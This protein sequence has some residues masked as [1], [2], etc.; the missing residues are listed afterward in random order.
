MFWK[1]ACCCGGTNQ[2]SCGCGGGCSTGVLEWADF[3]QSF[4]ITYTL[5]SL[6]AHDTGGYNQYISDVSFGTYCDPTDT[7]TYNF[8]GHCGACATW[9]TGRIQNKY[10]AGSEI[11]EV[12]VT[13]TVLMA[14]Q[15]GTNPN[16]PAQESCRA[17]YSGTVQEPQPGPQA[18]SL[19]CDCA[20]E[21]NFPGFSR[22]LSAIMQLEK[23]TPNTKITLDVYDG[24]WTSGDPLPS[25][26]SGSPPPGENHLVYE[27]IGGEL[28]KDINGNTNC[29]YCYF[30]WAAFSDLSLVAGGQSYPGAPPSADGSL[31]V[32]LSHGNRDASLLCCAEDEP[33]EYIPLAID[34]WDVYYWNIKTVNIYGN[35]LPLFNTADLTSG[36]RMSAEALFGYGA[37]QY[38]ATALCHPG[39]SWA[40]PADYVTPCYAGLGCVSVQA[41]DSKCVGPSV[42]ASK[43]Y[44]NGLYRRLNWS[45]GP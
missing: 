28:G 33:Y 29:G 3:P 37:N 4:T 10:V 34:I 44:G 9:G 1:R 16:L 39:G 27:G 19:G 20:T 25:P 43:G 42:S 24:N 13:V 6:G 38:W 23:Q 18:D 5:W 35:Q 32:T 40:D 21:Y 2:S 41:E 26:P 22:G 8:L 15:D 12:E 7:T 36:C 31:T 17:W 11:E 45:L 30:P 14:L